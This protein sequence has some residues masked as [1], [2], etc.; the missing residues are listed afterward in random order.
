MPAS[1]DITGMRS[2]RLVAVRPTDKRRGNNGVVWE[3]QCD[4]GRTHYTMAYRI[5]NK[6]VKS[7][8]CATREQAKKTATKLGL[9]K[10]KDIT[11]QVFGRLTALA[12]TGKKS[13]SDYIWRFRCNCGI[14]ITRPISQVLSGGTRSCGCL[15]KE[16]SSTDISGMRFG[17][18]VAIVPTDLRNIIGGVVWECKCDCGNMTLVTT[19]AV[20]RSIRPTRSCG[21]LDDAAQFAKFTNI[22]PMD[23]PFEITNVMKARR[24]LKK[25]IKQA[26]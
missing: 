23:V 11:G 5:S 26:S 2:G 10:K 6:S 1:K 14:I 18:L 13:R 22:N 7:C 19:T 16:S 12:C 9:L 24:E 25:V 15:A 20:R 8:G 3:C 21:C 4:C 17:R